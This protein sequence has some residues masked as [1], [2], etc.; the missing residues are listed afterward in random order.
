MTLQRQLLTSKRQ[1]IDI[2]SDRLNTISHWN[3]S[4]SCADIVL[5][6]INQDRLYDPIFENEESLTILDIGGNI[7]LFSLY[8][9][10]RAK[11]IYSVEPTPDHFTILEELTANYPNIKRLPYALHNEDTTVDFYI[12]EGNT[13][14]NSTVNKYGR[15]IEVPTRTLASLFAELGLDHVDFIK[16]D[17][18]GSEMAAI[19]DETVGAVADKVDC[20][21]V[22]V[23]ATDSTVPW[24]QSLEANRAHIAA[25]FQRQ[26]YQVQNYRVDGLYIYKE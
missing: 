24:A 15:K 18:E 5:N 1:V 22:E 3:N 2:T 23:H 9:Q 12:H 7:G 4:A 17:I 19:T 25:I 20:W 10:D 6:Q 11:V 21:F 8:V 16:C 14:M 13:T 26:G